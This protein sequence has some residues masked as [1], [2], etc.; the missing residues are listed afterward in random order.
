M[1]GQRLI[2]CL[3]FVLIRP[4][5]DACRTGGS[6]L[7]LLS[8]RIKD[9]EGMSRDYA[10]ALDPPM[11]E[12]IPPNVLQSDVWQIEA[13]EYTFI[14]MIALLVYDQGN[15]GQFSESIQSLIL[16]RK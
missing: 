7:W 1:L 15:V 11:S 6:T 4:D 2:V 10:F 13:I 16:K 12:F 14:S 5:T 9:T 3:P 8:E